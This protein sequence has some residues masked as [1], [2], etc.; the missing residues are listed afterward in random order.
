MKK[1]ES[2]Q[3]NT[4][5]DKTGVSGELRYKKY[6]NSQIQKHLINISY[7][8]CLSIFKNTFFA[9]ERKSKHFAIAWCS[10]S[11]CN[12]ASLIPNIRSKKLFYRTIRSDREFPKDYLINITPVYLHVIKIDI[13]Y[14]TKTCLHYQNPGIRT[15][16]LCYN[17][18]FRQVFAFC[19]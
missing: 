8:S 7:S 14:R 1:L 17:V 6:N 16:S 18:Y 12:S 2:I 15:N 5:L 11:S 13:K 10:S 9:F 4:A 3:H 19:S